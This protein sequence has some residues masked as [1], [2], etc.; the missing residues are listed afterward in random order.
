MKKLIIVLL[1]SAGLISQLASAAPVSSSGWFYT[2]VIYYGGEPSFNHVGPF[3]T[4]ADCNVARN[5]DYG[6]GG[7]I[8]WDGGPGCFYL[9]ESDIP[10]YNELL[11][12]W[13]MSAGDNNGL[14]NIGVD[15]QEILDSVTVLI[16]E[17]SIIRYRAS[18]D[19]LTR[20]KER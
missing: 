7:A 8:P 1:M 18:M 20:K 11:E 13:N 19:K 9:Y 16:E 12:H 10:S 17:H 3:S 6:D 2:S 15:F 14:P 4:S 5:N